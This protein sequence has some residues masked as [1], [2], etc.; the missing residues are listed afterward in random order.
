M[1]ALLV[2]MGIGFWVCVIP[3]VMRFTDWV[4]R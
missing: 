3:T 4:R 1:L 2:L